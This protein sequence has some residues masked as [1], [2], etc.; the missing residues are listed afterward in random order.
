MQNKSDTP[1]TTDQTGLSD[2][3]RAMVEAAAEMSFDWPEFLAVERFRPGITGF[4]VN[5]VLVAGLLALGG[6]YT[7]FFTSRLANGSRLRR[8]A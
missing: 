2:L 6:V 5:T 3:D 7:L 8:Y 1:D 4:A